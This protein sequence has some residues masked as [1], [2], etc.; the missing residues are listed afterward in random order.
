MCARIFNRSA[1]SAGPVLVDRINEGRLNI[2]NIGPNSE[3][4]RKIRNA[5]IEPKRPA[6]G[7]RGAEGGQDRLKWAPNRAGG[8][9]REAKRAPRGDQGG[10]RGHK[11]GPRGAQGGP[12]EALDL[13]TVVGIEHM[14]SPGEPWCPRTQ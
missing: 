2:L 10:S 5:E 13:M 7:R 14:G 8:G 1:H 4:R 9:P 6:E 12:G 3:E 11:G